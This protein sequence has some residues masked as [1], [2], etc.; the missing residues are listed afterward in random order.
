MFE[1]NTLAELRSASKEIYDFI[2]NIISNDDS[3]VKV[4]NEEDIKFDNYFGGRVYLLENYDELEG[5]LTTEESEDD[6]TQWASILEKP[7]A[8]DDCRYIA[9]NKYVLI[10]NATTDSGGS[11]YIIPREIAD[12][13]PNIEES[14]KQTRIAWG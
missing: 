9:E 13:C 11:T 8:F 1:Y 7:D 6:P 5:I 10:Y 4:S 2:Y 3:D 14:I 12:L